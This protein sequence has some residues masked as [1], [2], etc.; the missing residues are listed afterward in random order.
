MNNGILDALNLGWKLGFASGGGPS[1]DL[2]D[3]YEQER[4]PRR[5]RCWL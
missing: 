1:E 2:L 4:K 5:G 3:S